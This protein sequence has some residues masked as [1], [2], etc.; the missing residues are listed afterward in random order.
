M[1]KQVK[2]DVADAGYEHQDLS[3]RSVYGFLIGLAVGVIVVAV[4]LSGVYRAMDAYERNH[5]PLQSPLVP[6]T[7]TDTRVVSPNQ[8]DTF[9]QP[10]L[11]T[12]ERLE[13]NTFR[14]GEEQTLESYGWLDQKAGVLRIPIDRAMQLIAERGLATKVTAGSVPPAGG[15]VVNQTGQRAEVSKRPAKGKKQ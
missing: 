4:L 2:R 8:I 10:R 7:Q 3:P 9:P 6:E 15:D 5:Q 12:N 11:E 14:L 1:A 13:I